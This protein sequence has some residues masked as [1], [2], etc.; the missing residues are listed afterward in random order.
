MVS[1]IA[2]V[3]GGAENRSSVSLKRVEV[4]AR[5]S[6]RLEAGHSR[7]TIHVMEKRRW[8]KVRGRRDQRLWRVIGWEPSWLG[9]C[10]R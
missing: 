7:L 9:N 8:F 1:G 2:D 5:G 10:V 6:G 3:R 4:D